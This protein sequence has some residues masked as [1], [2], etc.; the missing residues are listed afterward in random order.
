[1]S[2]SLANGFFVPTRGAAAGTLV[3]N[4]NTGH[5]NIVAADCGTASYTQCSATING[6]TGGSTSVALRISTM[7]Q[8]SNITIQAFTGATAQEITGVQAVIDS[9]GRAQDILRRIQV[10]LPVIQ[11]GGLLP[12]GALSSNGS[13]CK[14]FSVYTNYFNIPGDI[15]DPDPTNAMCQPATDM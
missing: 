3:Y 14:R 2:G 4:S 12:N 5:A 8:P 9:T 7:Y 13:I 10:R 11:T 1:L 15:V 6:I